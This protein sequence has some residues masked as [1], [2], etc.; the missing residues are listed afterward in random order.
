MDWSVRQARGTRSIGAP[1]GFLSAAYLI[2]LP[3][4]TL[5]VYF[6]SELCPA[7]QAR[8]CAQPTHRWGEIEDIHV[9]RDEETGKSKGFAFLKYENQRSTDLAVD[10]VNGIEV[11][12]SI[13]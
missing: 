4:V 1:R 7:A 10:N 5:F 13:T 8:L 3:K 9:V 12:A 6:R 2:N 11:R